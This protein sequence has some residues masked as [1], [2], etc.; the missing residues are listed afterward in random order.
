VDE[1]LLA[2]RFAK[3]TLDEACAICA[4]INI[5]DRIGE[6]P[7]KCLDVVVRGFLFEDPV[8]RPAEWIA[9]P[10]NAHLLGLPEVKRVD[11]AQETS[12]V[13]DSPVL[14]RWIE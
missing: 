3:K 4:D 12:E 13:K 5:E 9:A 11:I 1:G 7:L 2:V 8:L 14:G 10:G 6:Q